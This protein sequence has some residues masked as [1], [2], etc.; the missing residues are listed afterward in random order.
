MMKSLLLLLIMTSSLCAAIGKVYAIFG[1]ATLQRDSTKSS[2]KLGS[3]LD[4]K[5]IIMTSKNTRMQVIF[6]DRTIITLGEKSH[7]ALK[8][9]HYDNR[10]NS[11]LNF[12]LKKG[13]MKTV[14]GNIGEWAPQSFIIATKTGKISVKGTSFILKITDK[15][16]KLATLSGET[17]YTD[18]TTKKRHTLTKNRQLTQHNYTKQ[19]YLSSLA[20]EDMNMGKPIKSP[21]KS[22]LTNTFLSKSVSQQK[23][24]IQTGLVNE[25]SFLEDDVALLATTTLNQNRV[26]HDHNKHFTYGYWES[27]GIAATPFA[28]GDEVSASVVGTY[29]ALASYSGGITSISN[30][31]A[32]QVGDIFIDADFLNGTISSGT[33]NITDGQNQVW[34]VGFTGTLTGNGFTVSDTEIYDT[35]GG[36]DITYTGGTINGTFY[37]TGSYDPVP[38]QDG[39]AGTFNLSGTNLSTQEVQVDGSYGAVN[40]NVT[41]Q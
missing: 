9:Y 40:S 11:H 18:K 3:S 14:T 37:G 41:P 21:S 26:S 32:S 19:L 7:L 38:G 25:K 27:G 34:G 36:D 28:E 10:D 23:D 4:V 24:E 22:K 20:Q 6:K 1:H 35:N 39:V 17:Y 5:D 31:V 16:T 30:G 15:Q 33:L 13:T 8:A 12:E 29:R 2:L